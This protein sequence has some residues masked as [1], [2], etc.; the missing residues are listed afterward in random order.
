M[1]RAAG[2]LRHLIA[3]QVSPKVWQLH[4]HH[5]ELRS[6]FSSDLLRRCVTLAPLVRDDSFGLSTQQSVE[7][8]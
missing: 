4:S 8:E 1:S 2:S 5:K 6:T 7:T 3:D